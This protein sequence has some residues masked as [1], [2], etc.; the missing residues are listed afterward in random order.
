MEKKKETYSE[1]LKDPRWQ[2]KRLEILNRDNFTCQICGHNDRTL[3]VHH[4]HYKKGKKPCEYDEESL[5]TLCDDCH[6]E[7]HLSKLHILDT[8]QDLQDSGF[9]M[10]EIE[11]VLDDVNVLVTGLRKPD[12]VVRNLG[13]AMEVKEPVDDDVDYWSLDYPLTLCKRIA[14]WRSQFPKFKR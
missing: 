11:A 4:I 7:E 9:L 10:I 1:L 5:I 14:R 8:I 3:H 13:G 12:G 2:K 6:E